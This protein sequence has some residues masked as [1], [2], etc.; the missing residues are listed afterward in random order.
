M[1]REHLLDTT[2]NV[3]DTLGVPVAYGLVRLIH[4]EMFPNQR[5]MHAIW[6]VGRDDGNEVWESASERHR[7]Q[8]TY[9]GDAYDAI[10]EMES[11]GAGEKYLDAV[12]DQIFIDLSNASVIGAGTQQDFSFPTITSSSSSSSSSSSA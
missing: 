8:A 1:P 12:A 11:V 4:I 3:D 5:I 6:E 10:M 9:S 2:I 7:K